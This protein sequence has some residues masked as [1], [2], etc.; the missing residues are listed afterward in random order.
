MASDTF[1]TN[2][3]HFGVRRYTVYNIKLNKP[4]N[5]FFYFFYVSIIT[6]RLRPDD[7]L[8]VNKFS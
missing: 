3:K 8:F 6:T 4:P 5:N 7:Y 1:P 2:G